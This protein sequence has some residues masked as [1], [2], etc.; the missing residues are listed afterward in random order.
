MNLSNKAGDTILSLAV[1]N[2][3]SIDV[4]SLIIDRYIRCCIASI[5][6]IW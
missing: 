3:C 6:I 5:L 2:N 4:I 1:K